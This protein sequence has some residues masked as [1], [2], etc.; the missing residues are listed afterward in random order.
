M[1]RE[2]FLLT[3]LSEECAEVAQRCSKSI[4]FG[5]DEIQEGQA[6]NNQERLVEE[7]RDL[8][9]ILH[10][11]RKEGY[12]NSLAV[13]NKIDSSRIVKIDLFYKYSKELNKVI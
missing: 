7:L 4:R 3:L 9:T 11:L 13:L 12:L 10:L 2:Q 8:M 5:L 1:N 6:K